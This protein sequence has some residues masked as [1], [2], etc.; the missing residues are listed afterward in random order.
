MVGLFSIHVLEAPVMGSER[1]FVY[2]R[3]AGPDFRHGPNPL[4]PS[5]IARLTASEGVA[6]AFR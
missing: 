6:L 1:S 4:P 5:P 2:E 3:N